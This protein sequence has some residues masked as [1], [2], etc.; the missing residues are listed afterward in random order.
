MKPLQKYRL[1]YTVGHADGRHMGMTYLLDEC[2]ALARFD[3][4]ADWD[5]EVEVIDTPVGK[6]LTVDDTPRGKRW[7]EIARLIEVESH[8]NEEESRLIFDALEKEVYEMEPP[9]VFTSESQKEL[10]CAISEVT[11]IT[12]STYRIVRRALDIVQGIYNN[13]LNAEDA[14]AHAFVA[15]ALLKNVVTK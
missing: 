4:H 13:E 9:F 8:T 1:E 11:C 6:A 15:A 7:Y 14:Q 12:E 10:S 3:G 5:E 2:I